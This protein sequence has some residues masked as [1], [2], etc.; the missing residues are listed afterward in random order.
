[1]SPLT[2]PQKQNNQENSGTLM[3]Q[4]VDTGI[5]IPSEYKDRLFKP[6]G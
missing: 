2:L 3:I 4:V 5:G 1:M 6:F